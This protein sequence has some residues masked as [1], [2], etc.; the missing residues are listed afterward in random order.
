MDIVA[1]SLLRLIL[2]AL[3]LCVVQSTWNCAS[4]TNTGTFTRSTNCTITGSNHVMVTNTL[5]IVGTNTDMNNLIT[6]TAA[7]KHRPNSHP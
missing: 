2:L 3:V 5:E 1:L 6:I 4:T 7:S